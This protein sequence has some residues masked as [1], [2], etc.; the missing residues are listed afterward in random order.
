M[1]RGEFI[2][3]VKDGTL[4]QHGQ[5]G[6]LL[7]HYVKFFSDV[8]DEAR[9]SILG[10]DNCAKI[11]VMMKH[12]WAHV[13]MMMGLG[14]DRIETDFGFVIY[15]ELKSKRREFWKGLIPDTMPIDRC[16]EIFWDICGQWG[17]RPMPKTKQV[18]RGDEIL[19][20]N[21]SGDG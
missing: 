14:K 6:E 5:R 18:A 20:F 17:V 15:R 12:E 2:D 7:K 8:S 10:S 3:R 13:E 4:F 19:D 9:K 21:V 1:N 16:R 11:G